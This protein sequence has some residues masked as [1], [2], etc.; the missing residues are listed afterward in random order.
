VNICNHTKL[1][2]ANFDNKSTYRSRQ[3]F[4]TLPTLF[5]LTCPQ[6]IDFSN[7]QPNCAAES[8]NGARCQT[9][10]SRFNP[11]RS[12]SSTHARSKL[13]LYYIY[14]GSSTNQESSSAADV[15]ALSMTYDVLMYISC[16]AKL[17]MSLW[18][19][20]IAA[21]ELLD[22]EDQNTARQALDMICTQ[23]GTVASWMA[24][25]SQYPGQCMPI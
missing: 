5:W 18:L 2:T 11:P 14:I 10:N 8:K 4:Q 1:E 25:A 6:T 16:T 7:E 24:L 3:P 15:M 21:T 13:R 19:V 9:H 17:K 20:F 12:S 22:K 23:R